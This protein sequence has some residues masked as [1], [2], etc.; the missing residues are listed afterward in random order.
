MTEV[1]W[2]DVARNLT[3]RNASLTLELA[4]TEET[5]KKLERDNATLRL[6]IAQ[7]DSGGGGEG[8]PDVADVPGAPLEPHGD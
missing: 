4:V 1:S 6:V 7:S 8:P 5:V 2:E 3:A